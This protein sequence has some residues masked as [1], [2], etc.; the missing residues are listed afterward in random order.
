[1]FKKVSKSVVFLIKLY[2]LRCKNKKNK[3]EVKWHWILFCTMNQPSKYLNINST[4]IALSLNTNNFLRCGNGLN[5]FSSISLSRLLF[6]NRAV[7]FV[8]P[9]NAFSRRFWRL[10]ENNISFSKEVSSRKISSGKSVSKFWPKCSSFTDLK[11]KNSWP[12]S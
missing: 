3:I 1:M 12:L 8:S 11:F 5:T 10:F 4:K 6:K 9:V 7:R 2:L